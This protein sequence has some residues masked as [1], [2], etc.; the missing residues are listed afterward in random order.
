MFD[1]IDFVFCML[2]IF[3]IDFVFCMTLYIA[4]ILK[5]DI[6]YFKNCIG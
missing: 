6:M 4:L 2:M 3:D 1:D 5:H